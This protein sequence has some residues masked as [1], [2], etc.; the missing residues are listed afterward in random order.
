MELEGTPKPNWGLASVSPRRREA[1]GLPTAAAAADA[2]LPA[3]AGAGAARL[4]GV[5][6]CR[7]PRR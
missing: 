5:L 3:V 7:L 4:Q 6:G 1:P 2:G